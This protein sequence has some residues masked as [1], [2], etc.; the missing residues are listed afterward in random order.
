MTLKTTLLMTSAVW[1]LLAFWTPSA[2][3]QNASALKTPYIS[4]NGLFLYR[5]SNFSKE[6]DATERNGMDLQEAELQIYADVDPY[7]RFSLLMS[8]EPEY[9]T[10]VATGKVTESWSFTPEE[11]FAELLQIPSTTIK[12][13]KFKAAFGKSN[14]LHTHAYPFVDAPLVNTTLLGDEGLNDVGVSAAVLLPTNWFSELTL[15]YLRGEG[16]NEEFNSPTPGDGVELAHWKNLWDL[17]DALT[18]EVG[19]SYAGGTNQLGTT[20]QLSGADLTFKW[21]PASGGKYQ[22][23]ILGTEYIDRKTP[24]PGSTTENGQGYNVWGQYQFAERWAALLRYDYLKVDGA[25]AAVNSQALTNDTTNKYS[26]SIVFSASEFSSYRLEYDWVHGP[27][28]ANGESNEQKLYLQAN[29]TIGSH[30]AHSY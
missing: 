27:Q 1:A 18:F 19:L 28:N 7:S 15:Q 30:P 20:T 4:A 16:E 24:Q 13:G 12:I 17:S 3:A 11:A 6:D 10:D 25:D 22:S 26:A 21:R 2:F 23:W 14:L 29:F 8:M 5:N 9:S